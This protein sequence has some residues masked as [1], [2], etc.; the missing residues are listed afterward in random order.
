ML[1]APSC[2]LGVAAIGGAAGATTAAGA[3]QPA[4]HAAEAAKAGPEAWVHLAKV[5]GMGRVLVDPAGRTLYAFS[6]DRRSRPTCS[7]ACA[8]AWPPLAAMGRPSAG[9]GASRS[10]LG[11]VNDAAGTMQVTYDRWPLYTFVEDTG[12]GQ[13]HG[14]GVTAFG[15]KWST[16]PASGRVFAT[17]ARRSTPNASTGTRSGHHSSPPSTGATGGGYGY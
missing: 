15:G 3:G 5:P 4:P 16:V 17:A 7:G 13:D 6:P 8:S 2:A 10:L 14:Q 1:L 11:M 12:P 9:H